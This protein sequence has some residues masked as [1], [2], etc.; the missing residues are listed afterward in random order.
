MHNIVIKEN[1]GLE[2]FPVNPLIKNGK[3]NIQWMIDVRN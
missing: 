3:R 1:Y 2:G